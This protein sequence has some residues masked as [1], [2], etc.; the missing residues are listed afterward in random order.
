MWQTVAAYMANEP[1]IIGY[2]ILNEP[3]GANAYKNAA[4]VLQPGVSNNKYMLAAYK[5]IYQSIR[6]VD[7]KTTIFFEPSVLDFLSE[8]FFDTPGGEAEGHQQVF[9]YHV[10]CPLVTPMGEPVNTGFCKYF[11]ELEVASK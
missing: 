9:S 2:E 8:G 5:K 6:S 11:D 3:I 7:K 10:Y 4:D 1:N